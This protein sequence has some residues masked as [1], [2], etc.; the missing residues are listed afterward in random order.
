MILKPSSRPIPS[1]LLPGCYSATLEGPYQDEFDQDRLHY[2]ISAICYGRYMC[3]RFY[4]SIYELSV[5]RDPIVLIR[6]YTKKA[7]QEM[8]AQ[9]LKENPGYAWLEVD[10]MPPQPL[11]F[12]CVR[13]VNN[14]KTELEIPIYDVGIRDL[15]RPLGSVSAFPTNGRISKACLFVPVS[16]KIRKIRAEID[17][18]LAVASFAGIQEITYDLSSSTAPSAGVGSGGIPGRRVQKEVRATE[19]EGSSVVTV[20]KRA[21]AP[22]EEV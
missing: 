17:R 21:I 16:Y 1:D 10:V 13:Y 4:V 22:G 6:E 8:R 7:I 9:I 11:L 14:S 5:V 19:R 15:K 20:P 12:I 3:R 18:N 2:N